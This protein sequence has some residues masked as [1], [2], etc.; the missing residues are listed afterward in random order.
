MCPPESKVS[1]VLTVWRVPKRDFWTQVDP[2]EPQKPPGFVLLWGGG[3]AGRTLRRTSGC[4]SGCSSQRKA[5]RGRMETNPQ[6]KSLSV[7][8]KADIDCIVSLSYMCFWGGVL[9][10]RYL[11]KAQVNSERE[12]DVGWTGGRCN[13]SWFTDQAWP[14]VAHIQK[15]TQIESKLLQRPTSEHML[16]GSLSPFTIRRHDRT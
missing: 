5:P 6:W 16:P 8:V 7:R 4:S 11:L 12:N 3:T 15:H 10:E 1:R 2:S 14:P 13:G 9:L